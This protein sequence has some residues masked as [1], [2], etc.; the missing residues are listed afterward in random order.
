MASSQQLALGPAA[1]VSKPRG[2]FLQQVAC[3]DFVQPTLV[4]GQE[5]GLEREDRRRAEIHVEVDNASRI[6]AI[7]HQAVID[8]TALRAHG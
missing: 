2:A 6:R 1:R 7:D 5:V 3:D 4:P 8:G